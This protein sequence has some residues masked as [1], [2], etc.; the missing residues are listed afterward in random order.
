MPEK[1]FN[2]LKRYFRLYGSRA[3]ICRHC[4]ME[5][6][7]HV[8]NK[9]LFDATSWTPV[10]VRD[11]QF[12]RLQRGYDD[13]YQQ[14]LDPMRPALSKALCVAWLTKQGFDGS[15]RADLANTLCDHICW[16]KRQAIP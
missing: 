2:D 13:L 15:L 11:E 10:R 6:K 9:C 1:L 16:S 3:Q 5:K 7:R 4:R 14:P 8:D 12:A